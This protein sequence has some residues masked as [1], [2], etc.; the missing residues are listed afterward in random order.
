MLWC[1][2]AREGL[3]AGG[4]SRPLLFGRGRVVGDGLVAAGSALAVAGLDDVVEATAADEEDGNKWEDRELT[5]GRAG[6][7]DGWGA[8]VAGD[9][10]SLRRAL[11]QGA[12]G[13]EAAEVNGIDGDAGGAQGGG[14]GGVNEGHGKGAAVGGWTRT[15]TRQQLLLATAAL[16]RGAAARPQPAGAGRRGSQGCARTRWLRAFD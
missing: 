1:L 4:V 8:V 14:E 6:A 10:C 16:Q 11:R 13:G 15:A 7:R 3:V 9:F 5:V 2:A 12:R